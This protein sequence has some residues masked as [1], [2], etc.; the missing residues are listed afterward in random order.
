MKIEMVYDGENWTVKYGGKE[1]LCANLRDA[2]DQA[3]IW[4]YYEEGVRDG[5]VSRDIVGREGLTITRH[6]AR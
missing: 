5:V 3:R 4:G 6:E 2:L 1:C